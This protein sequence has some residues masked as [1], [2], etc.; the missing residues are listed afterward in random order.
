MKEDIRI[1]RFS[2]TQQVAAYIGEK[3]DGGE[4]KPGD[5]IESETQLSEKLGV[6]RVSI[7]SAIQQ[8]IAIGK[9]ES[10]QGKGTY[11]RKN[12]TLFPTEL[13]TFEDS[14]DLFKVMQFRASI[15]RDA[16]FYAAQNATEE[17]IHYLRKNFME[18]TAADKIGDAQHS[19]DYDMYFH[20]KIAAMSGNQFYYDTLDLL[21]Q[22]TYE[23]HL[24]M[25]SKLGTRFADYFHPAIVD[26]IEQHDQKKAQ[27]RMEQ[28][29]TDFFNRIQVSDYG[30][31]GL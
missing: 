19:W 27:A 1:K 16:A 23:L 31:G 20:K 28:H 24:R 4:W 30:L 14:R 10:I 3:L 29:L 6:S 18:M 17:D 26:A 12:I 5:K 25:M 9:L 15:E 2:V 13:F 11:V 22:Q 8:F 21:F 7:R